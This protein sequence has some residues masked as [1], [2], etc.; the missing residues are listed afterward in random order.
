MR[1]LRR[2]RPDAGGAEALVLQEPREELQRVGRREHPDDLPLVDDDGGAPFVLGERLGHRLDGGPGLH[3]VGARASWPRPPSP[4]PD[5]RR[6]ESRGDAGRAGRGSRRGW[7]PATTGRW[8]IPRRRIVRCASAS[9]RSASIVA[10]DG[11]MCRAID[12]DRRR[13]RGRRAPWALPLRTPRSARTFGF[14]SS[15]ARMLWQVSQSEAMALPVGAAWFPSWQR[16]QPRK[17]SCPMLFGWRSPRDLH[18][19]EDVP[20]V[21]ALDGVGRGSPRRRGA[22]GRRPGYFVPVEVGEVRRRSLDSPPRA[23]GSRPSGA[24]P[25]SS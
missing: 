14:V 13:R 18:V 12:G 20:E 24:R 4:S 1:R 6:G 25:P 23:T 17:S 19:G 21:D 3:R 7:P 2:R 8:R 10:G 15:C 16:K 22:P 11:V 5:R 9:E